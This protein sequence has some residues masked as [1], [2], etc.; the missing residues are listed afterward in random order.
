[1]SECRASSLYISY[2]SAEKCRPEV[3][4]KYGRPYVTEPV[5]LEVKFPA[6][7]DYYISSGADDSNETFFYELK[8]VKWCHDGA[9]FSLFFG[10]NIANAR[11]C[12]E[13][14]MEI[15]RR[16]CEVQFLPRS[17]RSDTARVKLMAASPAPQMQ[18][19]EPARK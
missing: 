7:R 9:D 13:M 12:C 19:T 2:E 16:G 18:S 1:M 3:E 6:W 5:S 11:R 8:P 17:W 14:L 4:R 15:T 10:T